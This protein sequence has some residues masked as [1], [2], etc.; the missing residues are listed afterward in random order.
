LQADPLDAPAA[1]SI[2]EAARA[3][4]MAEEMSGG[5]SHHMSHGSYSHVDAGRVPATSPVQRPSSALAHDDDHSQAPEAHHH[6]H[7]MSAEPSP[8]PSPSA[9]PS[10]SPKEQEQ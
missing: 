8:S 4:E 10:P 1:S 2:E 3:Q 6:H 5:G 7:Q 9:H